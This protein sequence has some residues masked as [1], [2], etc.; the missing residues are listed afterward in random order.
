M[1]EPSKYR[2]R[3]RFRVAKK[4]N[5]QENEHDFSVGGR[6]VRLSSGRPEIAISESS[7]L[8][9]N[10][11]GFTTEEE[12]AAFAQDLR[13]ASELSSAA[14]RLGVDAGI[15]LPTSALGIAVKE[16]LREHHGVQTR[17]NI[18]GVDIFEDDPNTRFFWMEAAA[19]V[20]VEPSAFLGDLSTFIGYGQRLSQRA[21]DILLLLNYALMRPEPVAQIVFAI[22]AVEMLG[23]T[24]KWTPD[25]RKLIKGL[26]LCAENSTI[27]TKE[28][29][30]EVAS[31]IRRGLQKLGLKQGVVRLLRT[32]ELSRLETEWDSLYGE[33]S[34][35]VHGLAPKPGADYS[36][37]AFRTL[38]L[39]GRILLTAVAK[40]VP[41]VDR[42]ASRVYASI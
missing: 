6:K 1:S 21:R 8:V 34:T 14:S 17:D 20:R 19:T 42:H 26:G 5:I 18:H 11:Q 33:R 2:A 3:Y 38:S 13:V 41:G 7:W 24:E 39:C 40:E 25:Q 31:A 28:E 29:R 16:H 15:D 12:A 9:M 10:A 37:L 30:K 27:G 36:A 35:L 22:S 32:L 23:Q 4:L